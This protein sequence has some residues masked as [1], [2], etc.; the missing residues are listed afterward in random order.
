LKKKKL[1]E[2]GEQKQKI[3]KETLY[4]LKKKTVREERENG[5]GEKKLGFFYLHVPQAQTS[6]PSSSRTPFERNIVRFGKK[7]NCQRGERKLREGNENKKLRK[8][9]CDLEKKKK[10]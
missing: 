1:F 2:R 6:P 3:E 4:D 9:H 10:V 5:E 7:K 8:K